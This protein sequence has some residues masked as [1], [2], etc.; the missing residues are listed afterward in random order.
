MRESRRV[1]RTFR[2]LGEAGLRQ[3]DPLLARGKEIADNVAFVSA[4]VRTDVEHLT[5]AVRAL[6]DRLQ[7]ASDHMEERIGEFNVLMEVV[8][9][10]AEDIF[11][12]AASTIRGVRAGTR[13]L[14]AGPGSGSPDEDESGRPEENGAENPKSLDAAPR[15]TTP[16]QD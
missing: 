10:E 14:R 6:S 4:A 16:R 3:A 11:V 12:G 1:N 8:Q 7:Q 2:A 15:L 9:S 5:T 13:T